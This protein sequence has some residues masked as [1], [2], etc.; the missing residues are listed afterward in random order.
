MR[1]RVILIVSA[2]VNVALIAAVWHFA[3]KSASPA[4]MPATLGTNDTQY[5][6]HVVVRRQFFTWSEVE[7]ADYPTFIANLRDIGCPEQTIRDII[8]ADV[9]N[10]FNKRAAQVQTPGQQWWLSSTDPKVAREA[11]R[12]LRELEA[13]RRELL[14]S[15]LGPGW[16]GGQLLA[17][18]TNNGGI[19]LDGPVLGQLPDQTKQA[20]NAIVGRSQTE[21]EALLARA[22]AEGRQ[23]TPAELAALRE[24]TR[25]ELQGILP[26]A[27][28]EE[29][30]LRYSQNASELR[31][32]LASLRYFNASPE[33]FRAIFRASDPFDQKLAALAGSTDPNDIRQRKS[34]EAQREAAIKLAL[35]TRRYNLY[36]QL[37]NPGYRDAYGQALAAGDPGAAR[38]I[39]EVNEATAAQMAQTQ[40][41]PD[42]TEQQMAI[43]TQRVELQQL[44]ATALALGQEIPPDPDAPPPPPLPPQNRT[45]TIVPGDNFGALSAEYGVPVSAI[46]DANPGVQIHNLKPGQKL[47]I[48]PAIKFQQR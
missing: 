16:S 13:E 43:A 44:E 23:P 3:R 36:T 15:L 10:L 9:N 22:A 34:L 47:V 46:A 32:D 20:I 7:S 25:T 41:T 33:E 30:L 24:Q 38:T 27:Q 4:A 40:Q 17:G 42:L 37:Q 14:T 11:E 45:H 29:F 48:P 12:K 21:M 39:Y 1:W 28:L 19:A 26:P 6:T 18:Q 5:R 8:I 35:G 31:T 2:C